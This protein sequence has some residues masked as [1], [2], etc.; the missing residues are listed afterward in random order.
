MPKHWRLQTAVR[1]EDVQVAETE[2]YPAWLMALL[3]QRGYGETNAR[4][5]FLRG[6]VAE[7]PDPMLLTDMDKAV[8][9]L[10][11][12]LEQGETVA[13]FGDYDADGVTA[14]ALAVRVMQRLE[15]AEILT[16]IPDRFDEGYGLN[17]DALSYLIDND[18][19]LILTVDCGISALEEAEYL[20]K[21]GVDLII[22]DHHQV[23]EH[24]PNAC[25][26]I[27][28]LRQDSAYPC[29]HLAGVGVAYELMRA[30]CLQLNKPSALRMLTPLVAIG[31]LGDMMDLR[32]VN[33]ILVRDGLSTMQQ[34]RH[35]GIQ[36]LMELADISGEPSSMQVVFGMVPRLNAAGRMQHADI[37]LQLLL[38]EDREEAEDI[39]AELNALNDLRKKTE[40]E[41][42]ADALNQYA[43]LSEEDKN[44]KVHVFF[45]EDWHPG[46]VGIVAAKLVEKLHRPVLVAC[47]ED[48]GVKGSGRAP[49]GYN[50]HK[51]LSDS[52]DLFLRFG[53]H[54]QAAGFSCTHEN[55]PLL[56]GRLSALVP[57]VGESRTVVAA[58]MDAP[59]A[60]D[61]A[62]I[63]KTL[64]I[65]EP[66]GNGNE[67]PV[68]L[69]RGALVQSVRLLSQ[70]E[71]LSARL[72]Y[73]DKPV[74]II[75]WRQ[76]S[77]MSA[78]N[79]M[80]DVLARL[81]LSTF[82]GQERVRLEM[83]DWRP[84]E[85]DSLELAMKLQ[86]L[87]T[88]ISLVYS[89]PQ[90]YTALLESGR[91]EDEVEPPS[92]SAVFPFVPL[93]HGHHLGKGTELPVAIDP[94]FDVS[95]RDM[96]LISALQNQFWQ[97]YLQWLLPDVVKLRQY[98]RWLKGIGD[99]YQDEIPTVDFPGGL[100]GSLAD[101]ALRNVLEVFVEAGFVER[102]E[103]E[104]RVF[105]EY[106]E[107][108]RKVDI[109][110]LQP[111]K[112]MQQLVACIEECLV[113]S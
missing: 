24:L 88:N 46:V 106:R 64:R 75:A 113:K 9:R 25:A 67:E 41:V 54:F 48:S 68:W 72:L 60:S 49:E 34:A 16:Y 23:G 97:N 27:N 21:Q 63:Y 2:G 43:E 111:Y 73:Q 26:V 45:A 96:R 3:R 80:V 1:T 5:S 42:F 76:G 58:D 28:P 66:Y 84:S 82:R 7:L 100:T 108:P 65:M 11:Q 57:D 104:G 71:H 52:A 87:P 79:G 31:T 15:F 92:T 98:Y 81:V 110:E 103:A 30:L 70:G 83:V 36:A 13:V 50:L 51:L 22:T 95:V 12:A 37:A 4:K 55:L 90:S 44:S 35:A 59:A 91:A 56:R 69:L 17:M 53:G 61:W 74:E 101:M 33:R 62:S 29:N 109:T 47:L 89:L 40:Q 85:L 112:L 78:F 99:V 86:K 19:S 8:A 32:G 6:N 39:A 107:E 20:R 105:L 38:C 77:A 93:T 10:K 14:T 102:S 94:L 18:V